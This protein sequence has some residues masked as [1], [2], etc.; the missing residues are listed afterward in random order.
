MPVTTRVPHLGY[1]PK[2]IDICLG[3]SQFKVTQ[4]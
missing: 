2:N 1:K 4:S 3:V